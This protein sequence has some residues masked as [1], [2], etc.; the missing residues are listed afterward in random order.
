MPR[1]IPN[2]APITP[3]PATGRTGKHPQRGMWLLLSPFALLALLALGSRLMNLAPGTGALMDTYYE[4]QP[5]EKVVN[6]DA[7]TQKQL[8]AAVGG[9][10]A[11]LRRQDWAGALKFADASL[12]KDWTER[13]FQD[14]IQKTGFSIMPESSRQECRKALQANQLTTM[15]VTVR[16]LNGD[17]AGFVYRLVREGN[18]WRIASCTHALDPD[19]ASLPP[20]RQQ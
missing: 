12:Q 17:G 18:Q 11:A 10:L 8:E 1:G 7:A 4:V 14:I 15:L 9:Q 3:D 16:R 2:L 19:S 20:L 13:A 6:V 5:A